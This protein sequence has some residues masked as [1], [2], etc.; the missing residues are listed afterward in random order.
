MS[1]N[2]VRHPGH[3]VLAIGDLV[4]YDASF[5]GDLPAKIL[6]THRTQDHGREIVKVRLMITI[7]EPRNGFTPR[8]QLTVEACDVLPRTGWRT[9]NNPFH[10]RH[11][12]G[13]CL[14]WQACAECGREAP[15]HEEQKRGNG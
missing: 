1:D 9:L 3:P 12:L 6:G 15:H 4:H 11:L 10:K 2:M 5:V 13:W 7:R 14:A 8:E